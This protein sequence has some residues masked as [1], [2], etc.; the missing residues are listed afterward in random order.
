MAAH[1]GPPARPVSRVVQGRA[2]RSTVDAEA[3]RRSRERKAR[4]GGQIRSIRLRRALTQADLADRAGI[5]RQI[6]GRAE[7][8]VGPIDLETLERIS[9]ALDVPLVLD[10]GRDRA[11]DVSDAGH[12]GV[13]ELVL[14]LG[15]AAGL[16]PHFELATKP[17]EPWRSSDAALAD[18]PRRLLIGVEC[19]NDIGDVGASSRSSTRKQAELE[20]LA[21]ARWGPD[22]RARH[23]WVI[24]ATARNRDLVAR[25]PEVFAARFPGSSRGWVDALTS[26]AEPPVEPGLVWCDVGATRLY[27]WRQR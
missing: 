15:R 4:L 20:A 16:E 1:N 3:A 14:R 13:Q 5:G 12:L 7:R 23:V 18:N 19:W 22:G 10:F 2:R 6:V 17:A 21:V 24:R 27:E 25:Y 8:G 26:G 9:I 11:R